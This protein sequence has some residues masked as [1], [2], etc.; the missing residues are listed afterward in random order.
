MHLLLLFVV[1]YV[2]L[3]ITLIC[4]VH[5]KSV[6]PAIFSVEEPCDLLLLW[7]ISHLLQHMTPLMTLLPETLLI[8]ALEN[9]FGGYFFGG[10]ERFK[11]WLLHFFTVTADL[12]MGKT[13]CHTHSLGSSAL[14]IMPWCFHHSWVA[15]ASYMD[16]HGGHEGIS[17]FCQW[18]NSL[19]HPA[20]IVL[21]L[22]VS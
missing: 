3:I 21:V 10:G 16:L 1:Y 18:L 11:C 12:T 13:C 4:S 9:T 20:V 15:H 22:R 5:R 19:E 17:R 2:S 8:K 14:S 6:S 7:Q